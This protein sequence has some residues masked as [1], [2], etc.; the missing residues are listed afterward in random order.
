MHWPRTIY[1][2]F[3]IP[4]LQTGISV[5]L[6]PF[7]LRLPCLSPFLSLCFLAENKERKPWGGKTQTQGGISWWGTEIGGRRFLGNGKAQK[8]HPPDWGGNLAVRTCHLQVLWSSFF[9][10]TFS[11]F[12]FHIYMYNFF[13]ISLMSSVFFFFSRLKIGQASNLPISLASV[14]QCQVL[15]RYYSFSRRILFLSLSPKF[16]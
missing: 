1:F 11:C 5:Y 9:L 12:F 10:V 3:Y 6:I 7:F 16:L 8:I 2:T 14:S 4:D 15:P 13:S